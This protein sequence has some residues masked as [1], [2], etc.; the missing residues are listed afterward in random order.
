M[1]VAIAEHPREDLVL[2]RTTVL[3]RRRAEV[4]GLFGNGELAVVRDAKFDSW[5]GVE[6]VLIRRAYLVD[7]LP[8]SVTP[9]V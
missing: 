3:L 5:D 6:V 2:V 4:T 1:L 9:T 7:V 8:L